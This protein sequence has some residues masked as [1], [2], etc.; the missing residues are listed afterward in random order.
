MT[1]M[2]IGAVVVRVGERVVAVPV[3]VRL[4]RRIVRRV[5]VAMVLVVNVAVLVLQSLV[6]MAMRV[7]LPHE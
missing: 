3:R 2:Q 7:P 6:H 5:P 4:A 1:V